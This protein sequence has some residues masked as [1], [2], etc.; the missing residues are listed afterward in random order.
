MADR[1]VHARRHNLVSGTA[2]TAVDGVKGAAKGTWNWGRFGAVALAIGGLVA[3]VALTS[4]AYPLVQAL[5]GFGGFVGGGFLGGALGAMGGALF[6][7]ISGTAHG[8]D[9]VD[10]EHKA[11]QMVRTQEQYMGMQAQQAAVQS[12]A[13]QNLQVLQAMEQQAQQ[14]SML[15]AS[16][17]VMGAKKAPGT[18]IKPSEHMQD[19]VPGMKEAAN[20]NAVNPEDM[21][22]LL[23][24]ASHGDQVQAD[25]ALA[26]HAETAR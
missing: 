5:V 8:L 24:E 6:G 10:S 13:I 18:K 1:A 22:K 3:G 9:R 2:E 12:Q 20:D 21:L 16:P 11:H 4:G 25:K 15:E 17:H 7:G 23:A 14:Q 26:E 19:H